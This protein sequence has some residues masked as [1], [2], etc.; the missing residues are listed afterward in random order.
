MRAFYEAREKRKELEIKS[1]LVS[2]STLR[3]VESV[4][5]R[6]DV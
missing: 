2:D 1:Q 5:L 6:A 3:L 4:G